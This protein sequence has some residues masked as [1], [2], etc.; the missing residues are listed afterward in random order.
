LGY[1]NTDESIVKVSLLLIDVD[2]VASTYHAVF[3][4]NVLSSTALVKST[5]TVVVV[6]VVG[7]PF[8]NI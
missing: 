2:L 3:I 6:V 1:A 5:G 8:K 7:T 4:V